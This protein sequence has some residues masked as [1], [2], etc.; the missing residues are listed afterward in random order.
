ML[1]C[2]AWRDDQEPGLP[3]DCRFRTKAPV[4]TVASDGVVRIAVIGCGSFGAELSSVLTG[5]D[6]F[7]IVA[8]CD[9][10]AARAA[11]LGEQLGVKTFESLAEVLELSSVS[12][13]ALCTP[14]DQHSIQTLSAASAGRHIFCEKPMAATVAECEAMIAAADAAHVRLMVGHKRRLRP[15]YRKMAEVV[16]SGSMGRL[17]MASVDGFFYRQ[18]PGWWAKRRVGGGLL[19][20]AGVHD[21]DFLNHICGRVSSVYAASP[22]KV[23]DQTDF[24]DAMAV[25]ISYVSGAIANLAVTWRFPGPTFQ[26]SFG[27]RLMFEDGGITYDPVGAALHLR[28]GLESVERLQY[29][30]AEGFTEA[31]RMELRSFANWITNGTAPVLTGEDGLRCVEVMEAAQRSVDSGRRVSLPFSHQIAG[32]RPVGTQ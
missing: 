30:Q 19:A 8:V 5:M 17:L 2:R 23:D 13:V 20:Y 25:V 11:A 3:R 4:A 12:A 24:V 18:P 28:H 31:Y 22:P 27:V 16:E 7:Q 14:N 9:P 1:R 21:I 32:N 29:D 10:D 15:Q 6:C 26:E